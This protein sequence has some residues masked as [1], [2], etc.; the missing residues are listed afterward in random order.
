MATI[1]LILLCI[2]YPQ[3]TSE[4]LPEETA[5][6]VVVEVEK[7]IP[8]V[9][10]ILKKIAWCESQNR[11]FAD[12]GSVHR[13]IINP[14]D[15]GKFQVNEKYHLENSKKLGIDIYTLEGNT[16][17]ALYLYRRNGTVDWNWSKPC[18]GDP[19]RVWWE[20]DGD[21]WSTNQKKK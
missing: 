1:I 12:D 8:D 17:Y 2:L 21:Y 6:V 18:W 16:E 10:V 3:K 4:I 7:E 13:G 15:T 11:Q 14:K 19:A 9:P 5:T 20:K